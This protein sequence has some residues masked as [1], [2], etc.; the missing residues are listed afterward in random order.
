[1]L[2]SFLLFLLAFTAIGISS[3]R[4]SQGSRKD[5]YLASHSVA[6]WLVGLSA[7]ATNNSGY[8]FIGVIGYTYTTG[9]GAIWLMVGWITGD[10]L[11]SLYIHRHIRL[12][13]E[14]TGEASFAAVL[15]NWHGRFPVLQ[16]AAALISVIFLISYASAQLLAGSKALHVLLDWPLWAGSVI[17]AV[18]VMAYCYAG[19]IRASI[20]TDA[21]QSFVMVLAMGL[22]L[23]TAVDH[24]GGVQSTWTEMGKIP[25]F[26]NW[27]PKD[28]AFPGL[29]GGVLFA[30]SWLFAG[31]S[32]VGQP[33]IMVRFMALKD[34][35]DL[36]RSR[37]WYYS[38]FTIFYAMA[39]GVGMLSR[40]LLA[41]PE[42]FDAELA[43]PTMAMQLFP[44]FMVGIVLA[45]IFA[46][47]MSTAD[48]LVLSS[49]AAFTHDLLPKRVEK[50]WLIKLSTVL[51]TL[52]ALLFAFTSKETVF[53][54]VILS[55]SG[56]ASSFA[57]LLILYAA[58]KKPGQTTAVLMMFGGLG[59]ALLW[60][61]L[62][63]HSAVYEGMPGIIIGIL[64]YYLLN[65]FFPSDQTSPSLGTNQNS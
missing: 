50:K 11:A 6:P 14:S 65:P 5:Y 41:N 19:G 37:V 36:W 49:S 23:I 51:T 59:T 45:G 56:L 13:T 39:T 54:L 42:T 48:S 30:L 15:S 16:R 57:P 35:D 53:G 61:F 9:L 4:K 1:M 22:L 25:G 2:F 28:M 38:W 47:T 31:F 33:H 3:I 12:T 44:P 55:W 17:G 64:L 58:G 27:Y 63:W 26:L 21:A 8:M 29:A 24:L 52:L 10:F 60:R 20:W 62:G 43:L 7:V 18:L 46:A 34:P 40:V 32:V